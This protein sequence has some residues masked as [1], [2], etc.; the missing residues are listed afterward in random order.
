MMIE[1]ANSFRVPEMHSS[2]AYSLLH[3]WG[4]K[5]GVALSMSIFTLLISMHSSLVQ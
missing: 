5:A 4:A 2:R 3:R 1:T